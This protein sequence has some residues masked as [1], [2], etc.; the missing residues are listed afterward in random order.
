MSKGACWPSLLPF[1]LVISLGVFAPLILS[2]AQAGGSQ[3]T[4]GDGYT[5]LDTIGAIT[6]GTPYTSGQQI[7]VTVAPNPVLSFANLAA[8]GTPGCTGTG[9]N[10]QCTGDFYVYECTDPGGTPANLPKGQ[11]NC[12]PATLYLVP[13][14]SNGSLSLSGTDAL[15]VYDLPDPS[16]LGV[17]LMTGQCDV[18]PNQCVVGIFSVNP[19]TEAGF[20]YPHLFSA[21]FQVTVGDGQDKGD[22]PG[23]G[24]PEVGYALALPIV[25]LGLTGGAVWVR[26]RRTAR[27]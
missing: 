2:T 21:P 8:A 22:N 12:E 20:P 17:P 13:K 19:F 26:A 15:T 23:D 14:T 7:S 18:A 3:L 6:P 1:A 5:T 11:T 25:A 9:A 4:S 10:A 24:T 16:T 27:V